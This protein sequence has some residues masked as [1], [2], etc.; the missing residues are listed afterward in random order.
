MKSR[1]NHG[2]SEMVRRGF[3]PR[4]VYADSSKMAHMDQQQPYSQPEDGEKQSESE[5]VAPKSAAPSA[6]VLQYENRLRQF[7]S[8]EKLFAYF[9]SVNVQG[10]AFMTY[11][12]LIL[13]V[14]PSLTRSAVEDGTKKA[15]GVAASG[16]SGSLAVVPA[17]TLHRADVETSR[18]EARRRKEGTGWKL[19]ISG[20][21]LLSFSEYLFLR[22]ILS[23]PAA[24]LKLA[25]VMFDADGSGKVDAD[26]F[27]QVL[28]HLSQTGAEPS[29]SSKRLLN[30]SLD[31]NSP[32]FETFFG[33]NRTGLLDFDTFQT[34]VEDVQTEFWALEFEYLIKKE[35]ALGSVLD[36]EATKA[37][38]SAQK[39]ISLSSFTRAI[40]ERSPDKS[41]EYIQRLDKLAG[42]SGWDNERISVNEWI[43]FN[44]FLQEI[45]RVDKAIE[46]YRPG[47]HKVYVRDF[48]RAYRAITDKDIPRVHVLALFTVFG[49]SAEGDLFCVPADDL[50]RVLQQRP[51]RFQK[52]DMVSSPRTAFRCIYD[53][54]SNPSK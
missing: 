31:K 14:T 32:L 21:G 37:P 40:V 23:L 38:T 7:S 50:W 24:N 52:T 47:E 13:S 33:A 46:M 11:E 9:A 51:L 42:P 29:V 41:A 26:E 53:C 4:I 15:W 34:F 5:H 2:A 49:G 19:D 48:V 10:E 17:P 36:H 18:R 12:D 25:F 54:V 1:G 30:Q 45:P 22:T 6:V 44:R 8:P 16:A 3:S 20:D 27:L 43:D 39:S 35:Q 28:N